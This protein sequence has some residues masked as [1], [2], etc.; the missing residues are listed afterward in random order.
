MCTSMDEDREPNEEPTCCFT[1]ENISTQCLSSIEFD[2]KQK[3]MLTN[4]VLGIKHNSTDH[5]QKRRHFPPGLH[6][7]LI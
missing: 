1:L 2:K 3:L 5:D 6:L 7:P 4:L